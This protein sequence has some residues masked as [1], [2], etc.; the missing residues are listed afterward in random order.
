MVEFTTKIGFEILQ[1]FTDYSIDKLNI[2]K[3][4]KL[5]NRSHVSL[6]PHINNLIEANILLE[7]KNGRNREISLNKESINCFKMMTIAENYKL[8]NLISNNLVIKKIVNKIKNFDL[9]IVLFGSY[10]K[11]NFTDE[12]DIDIAIFSKQNKSLEDK[13]KSIS[14]IIGKEIDIK[15]IPLFDS[16][17]HLSLEILK[18]H[19]IL[20]NPEYLLRGLFYE[21]N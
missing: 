8:L 5:T 13:F 14:N 10:A 15:F 6:L 9:C 18:D 19:I 1:V 21:K 17:D 4:S 7:E 20:N 11:N 12:S 2:S 3:L 16:S